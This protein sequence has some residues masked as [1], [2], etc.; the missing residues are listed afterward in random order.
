MFRV[1]KKETRETSVMSLLLILNIF[2]RSF[3][4]FVDFEQLHVGWVH[5]NAFIFAYSNILDCAMMEDIF[6]YL[7]RIAEL[8]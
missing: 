4:S 5:M 3:V 8:F 6:S 7:M 2:H 1:N